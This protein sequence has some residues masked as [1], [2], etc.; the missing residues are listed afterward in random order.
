MAS[1]AFQPGPAPL[2]FLPSSFAAPQPGGAEPPPPQYGGS[3]GGAA[4]GGAYG[5]Q[6]AGFGGPS[7]GA[8]TFDAPMRRGGSMNSFGATHS[9]EDEPPLLEGAPHPPGPSSTR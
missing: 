5:F 8:S 9:F 1:H 4:G 7:F 2:P 6:P 3:V